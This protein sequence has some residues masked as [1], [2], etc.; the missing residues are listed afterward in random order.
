[1]FEGL[2]RVRQRAAQKVRARLG[3]GGEWSERAFEAETMEQLELYYQGYV[4]H[5]RSEFPKYALLYQ[6]RFDRK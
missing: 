5:M 6:T 2:R 1:M 4:K 3:K